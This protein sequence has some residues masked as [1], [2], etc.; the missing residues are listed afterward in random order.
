MEEDKKKQEKLSSA[1][2][3]AK[4]IVKTIAKFLFKATLAIVL[5]LVGAFLGFAVS[6]YRA[7]SAPQ[8]LFFCIGGWAGWALGGWIVRL[9]SERRSR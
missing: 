4:R 7:G 2:T 3:M 5:A 9:F 8:S 6:G 1:E